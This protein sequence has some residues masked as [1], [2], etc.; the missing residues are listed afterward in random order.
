MEALENDLPEKVGHTND[1][2]VVLVGAVCFEDFLADHRFTQ[3]QD[4]VLFEGK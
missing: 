2:V 3:T 1:G 4:G